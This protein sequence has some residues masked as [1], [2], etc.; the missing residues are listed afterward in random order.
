VG[1][2]R[3]KI[4]E[5]LQKRVSTTP[6][7]WRQFEIFDDLGVEVWKQDS[8]HEEEREGVAVLF[9]DVQTHGEKEKKK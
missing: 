5:N 9:V 3:G 4:L 6:I 1:L 2:G 7:A 8:S